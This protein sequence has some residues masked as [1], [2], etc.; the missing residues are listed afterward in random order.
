MWT[1]DWAALWSP[2]LP[3]GEIVVRTAVVFIYIQ[4]LIR[5]VGRK[6]LA[7]LTL[8]DIVVVLLVAPAVRM[9]IVGSDGSLTSAMIALATLAG[10]DRLLSELCRRSPRWA[11]LLQGPVRKLI[12]GG[13]LNPRALARAGLSD[14]DLEAELHR[15]GLR[16][17]SQV[18]EAY[19]EHTGAVTF[20]L[21]RR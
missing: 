19:L 17:L 8:F 15:H 9:A 14:K 18:D 21:R 1:I 11:D 6:E 13:E 12:T 4:L 16:D 7:R 3:P 20:I 2:V 10:L 5:L